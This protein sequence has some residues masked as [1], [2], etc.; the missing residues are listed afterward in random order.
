MELIIGNWPAD[1]HSDFEQVKRI[2]SGRKLKSKI[3]CFD[4]DAQT[5]SIQGSAAEPYFTTLNECNCADYS[6][7]GKPC[8]HIYALAFELGLMDSLPVYKKQTS[9]FDAAKEIDKYQSLYENGEISADAY[10]KICSVLSKL[11]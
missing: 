6:I 4:A 8:K 2:E 7:Q 11:K 10:V 1:I 9:T 3:V 5:I